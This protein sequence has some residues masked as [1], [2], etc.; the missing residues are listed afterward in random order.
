MLTELPWNIRDSICLYERMNVSFNAITELPSVLPLR[1]PH[2]SHLD[3]SHNR[4]TDLPES[5]GLLFHLRTIYLSH[6]RLRA[7]PK[8]F[9]HLVK[10]EKID[11]SYNVLRQLVDDFGDMESLSK[12]NVSNNKLKTIP[13]SLG[14]CPTLTLLLAGGNKLDSPPQ[15]ICN[16]GSQA[17]IEFL[18]K[19]YNTS[20]EEVFR[21]PATPLNEFPRVRGYQLHSSV[22]NPQSAH[23]Q[24]IQ[25][26]THTANTPSR[27]KTPLL[28]P[29][30]ASSLDSFELRDRILG[31]DPHFVQHLFSFTYK[32]K[33]C[34]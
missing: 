1:L 11:L 29:L 34:F 19:L 30:G 22:A 28:P 4:L 8:S 20:N 31:D 16:E 9:V 14:N 10:L 24:Y 13:L 21:R 15:A 32:I 6:N 23:V 25:E 2:L 18:R 12:L 26:Q 5:F 7:L 3:I 27:I 33:S 17:T